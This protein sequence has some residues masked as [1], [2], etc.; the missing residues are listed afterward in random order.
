MCIYRVECS[1]VSMQHKKWSPGPVAQLVASR[2]ADPGIASLILE[3]SHTF[4]EIDHD[5]I[6]M[7][8]LLFLLIQEGLLSVT[9]ESMCTLYWLTA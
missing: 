6:S 9:S 3:R 2:T 5:I 1:I 7:V 8:I 4:M